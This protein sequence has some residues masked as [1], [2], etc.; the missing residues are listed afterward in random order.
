M[1]VVV[2]VVV[3]IQIG[4]AVVVPIAVSIGEPS[5]SAHRAQVVHVHDAVVVVVVVLISVVAAVIIV[6]G[7]WRA[8]PSVG[9]R[10]QV[11]RVNDAVVVIVLVFVVVPASVLIAV[12]GRGRLP[13]VIG[14]DARRAPVV[15][16]L[17][18]VAVL[19]VAGAF[20]D[21]LRSRGI[22]RRCEPT[23]VG[24]GG[25]GVGLGGFREID[26]DLPCTVRIQGN[27]AVVSV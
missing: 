1:V 11:V 22:A 9:F 25:D 21:D 16:V 26:E 27:R 12:G 3:F 7:R 20:D 13:A 14:S 15:G 10:T 19:V 18:A 17:N 4:A 24:E 2:V 5:L 6:I 23:A 8:H